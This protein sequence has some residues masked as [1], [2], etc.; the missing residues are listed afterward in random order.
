MPDGERDEAETGVRNAGHARVS[1]QSHAR[2]LLEIDDQLGGT[3]HLVVFVVADA[4]GSDAVVIQE[5]LRLASIFTGDQVNFFEHAQRTQRDVFQ[6]SD[7]GCDE[8]K[9][10]AGSESVVVGVGTELVVSLHRQ[11][12]I[13]LGRA[14]RLPW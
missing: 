6:I 1:H 13:T 10:R 11:K 3:S 12:S 2:T 5:L 14:A 7:R 8:I 9:Y 4:A